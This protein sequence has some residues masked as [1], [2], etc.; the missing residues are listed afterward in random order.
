[1]DLSYAEKQDKLSARIR[2]HKLFA[3]F[4]IADWIA[5][6]LRRKPRHD[7]FDLG[8]GNGN[9]IPLYLEDV[10]SDGR[11]AG[12]DRERALIEEVHAKFGSDNR[13]DLRVGSMDERLPFPDESF[14]L[15]FSNF[16]IY[17]AKDARKTLTELRRIMQSGAEVVLIGPTANNAKEL[18]EYNE[19]LTGMAIDPITLI[20][21][22]RIRREILPIVDEI[23]GNSRQEIINSFLMFPD[24]D[25]FIRYFQATMLYEE[26]AE[27]MHVTPEQM[28]AACPGTKNVIL[29]K[30][31]VAGIAVKRGTS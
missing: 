9:H 10:P 1:M 16:A 21:T 19:R 15:C 24:Q 13:V 12:L 26:G 6:F 28:H 25:E 29:S 5:D 23:F 27:K 22:D 3:N 2:A 20:R 7:I 4:D 18:Y 8:C 14:D 17:N 30:E 31:M 11:V